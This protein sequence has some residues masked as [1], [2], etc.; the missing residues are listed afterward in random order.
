LIDVLQTTD[1]PR[2]VGHYA[3]FYKVKA[4]G[5][6]RN[7]DKEENSD[8]KWFDIKNPPK[9][10]WKNHKDVMKKLQKGEI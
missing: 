10:G 4:S 2:A 5:N 3:I 1:D 7:L 6:I 9:I 8:I